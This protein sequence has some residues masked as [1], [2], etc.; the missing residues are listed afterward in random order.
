M[1]KHNNVITKHNTN[2]FKTTQSTKKTNMKYKL[3]Y[4]MHTKHTYN[5][6]QTKKKTLYKK[7]HNT[8]HNKKS[9]KINSYS[10]D[11]DDSEKNDYNSEKNDYDSEKKQVGGG[12]GYK[13]YYK[14]TFGK[15]YFKTTN[16][17]NKT[18]SNYKEISFDLLKQQP[19]FK[20]K[21]YTTSN[22]G[23]GT[24]KFTVSMDCNPDNEANSSS[25][26]SFGYENKDY[27]DYIKLWVIE[28][29]CNKTYFSF[30]CNSQTDASTSSTH[31]STPT[32]E[33]INNYLRNRRFIT[34]KISATFVI[35]KDTQNGENKYLTVSIPK[36]PDS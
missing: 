26:R 25:S 3:K 28:K 27:K 8:K 35:N 20:I 22:K 1:E 4:P 36:V 14:T 16:N 13:A 7:K 2:T 29:K 15:L 23:E 12:F 5:K 6:S 33:Q 32:Q 31:V 18:T 11:S 21:K 9:V 19:Y 17:Y 10:D 34:L 24:Y 30:K